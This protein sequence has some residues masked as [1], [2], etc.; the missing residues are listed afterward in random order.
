MPSTETEIWLA[1]KPRVQDAAGTLAIAWPAEDF[2]PVPGVPFLQVTNVIN[3]P[4]RLSIQRGAHDRTGTLALVLVYPLGQA[5]EVSLECAG[6]IAAHFPEDLKLRYGETCVRIETA[7]HV[8]DGFRDGA[9]WRTP[10]NIFW[11]SFA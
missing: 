10:I 1:I 3:R 7:P 4:A 9:W 2:A 5:V 8:L 11:R 6:Q